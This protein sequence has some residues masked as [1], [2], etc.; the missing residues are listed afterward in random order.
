MNNKI[1]PDPFKEDND[2]KVQWIENEDW[3][4]QTIFKISS[5]ELENQNIELVF[6]GLDTFS[7]ILFKWKT[8][9]RN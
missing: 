8:V 6:Y 4:Y 3:D 2:K 7:D 9:K 1:I 5:K